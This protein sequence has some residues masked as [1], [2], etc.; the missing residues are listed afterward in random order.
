MRKLKSKKGFTLVELIITI[1]VAAIVLA[2]F[3]LLIMSTLRSANDTQRHIDSMQDAQQIF[4]VMNESVRA[5]LRSDIEFYDPYLN[6]GKTA[7][8]IKSKVFFSKDGVGFVYQ[9]YHDTIEN[10]D[11]QIVL[12]EFVISHAYTV[13]RN[14]DTTIK[15]IVLEL[16]VDRNDDDTVDDVFD[17][18]FYL[19]Q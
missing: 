2:P 18:T 6:T 12:S 11:S 7:L 17:T 5:S 14:A 19:R 16:S 3:S 1:G 15:S 13:T 8:K 9:N 10:V 4:I